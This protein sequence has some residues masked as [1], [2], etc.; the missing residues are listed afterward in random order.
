M[1]NKTNEWMTNINVCGMLSLS[2]QRQALFASKL[3][4]NFVHNEIFLTSLKGFSF[5]VCFPFF[6]CGYITSLLT[7]LSNT[8]KNQTH[9]YKE[10]IGNLAFLSLRCK[11]K[12]IRT[13]A[14][15]MLQ[16]VIKLVKKGRL[17]PKD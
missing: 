9:V 7:G 1:E 10:D 2:K 5:F 13:E 3:V 4:Q 14:T 11:D 12:E 15:E 17:L 8:V 6:F 16:N